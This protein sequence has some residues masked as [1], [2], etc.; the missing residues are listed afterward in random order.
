MV[1][2]PFMVSKPFLEPALLETP[3]SADLTE[4]ITFL[5]YFFTAAFAPLEAKNLAAAANAIG[6]AIILLLTFPTPTCLT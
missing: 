3:F 6:S 5:P 1:E 4:S 2:V